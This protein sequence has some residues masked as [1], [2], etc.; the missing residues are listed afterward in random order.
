MNKNGLIL[1]DNM[2]W[3]GRLGKKKKP[4]ASRWSRHQRLEPQIGARFTG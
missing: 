2:L 1:F 3:G 4:T